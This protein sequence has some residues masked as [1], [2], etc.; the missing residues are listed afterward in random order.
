[1]PAPLDQH[2]ATV[3][4]TTREDVRISLRET[5][6]TVGVELRVA[7]NHGRGPMKETP[8]GLRLPPER[9]PEMIAALEDAQR[10][11]VSLGLLPSSAKSRPSEE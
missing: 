8:K 5:R 4:R 6:G 10:L 11:A 1:M 3:R 7:T 2:V 9:L